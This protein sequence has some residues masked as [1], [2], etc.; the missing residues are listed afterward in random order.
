M[1]WFFKSYWKQYAAAIVILGA[2]GV[3]EVLPPKML[4]SAIDKLREGTLSADRVRD[5]LLQLMVLNVLIY[6]MTYVWRYYLF[7]GAFHVERQLRSRLMGHLLRMTPF[8]FERNR[9]GDLM[10]R[11]TNDLKAVS[12]T[13]GMGMMT[14]CDSTMWMLTI[15]TMM[16][17]FISWELTAASLLPLPLIAVTMR[18]YGKAV[19]ERFSAAQDAFGR[20]NDRV[21]ETVSGIRVL[22]AFVQESNDFERFR[23]LTEDVHRK[24][25]DVARIDSLFDPTVKALVGLSYMI[26]IGYGAYLVFHSRLTLG[27]LVSF[28]IYL[29]MLIWPMFAVGQFINI[30]QRGSASLDRVNETLAY[31]PDVTEAAEPLK[32]AG[33]G[34]IR[35]ERVSFAYPSASGLQLQDV[36]F[37]LREGGTLGVVGRT[38]SG[39]TT[40]LRQLLREYPAGAGRITLSGVPIE[41]I[42]LARLHGWIGYVP[43]DH[44]LFSRTVREN[45]KFGRPHAGEAELASALDA[46]ALTNDLPMLPQGLDTLVGEKGVALSG[47]QKQRVSLARALLAEPELLLL[48]DALSAVDARTEAEIIAALRRIRAGRTTIIATHRLSAVQHA[49]LILVLDEGRVA[50]SGTHGQLLERGGW[51]AEQFVLQQLE[52]TTAD[53]RAEEEGESPNGNGKE[54]ARLRS[55]L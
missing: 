4:G 52:E 15:L 13:A 8:F 2:V 27:E 37:T 12:M 32:P 11:A 36:S 31:K 40:L 46:A 17:A 26:G 22:R 7:G 14:L 30:M 45:V 50:E 21:L 3:L 39:K 23:E 29:G 28:N 38:G 20:V 9:T 55:L 47:G 41:S 44:F 10:A 48:D 5:L 51:Y 43:Q 33:A 6:G 53:S 18:Y 54:A 25:E 49:D 42:S 19:H 16:A 1:D 24:N 35:F 34:D